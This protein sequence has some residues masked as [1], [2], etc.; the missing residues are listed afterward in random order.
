MN[1]HFTGLFPLWQCHFVAECNFIEEHLQKGDIV[2]LSKCDSQLS[3]CDANP[4]VN[5][6]KCLTCMSIRENAQRLLTKEIKSFQLISKETLL[7]IESIKIPNFQTREN[8]QSYCWNGINAGKEVISSIVTATGDLRFCPIKNHGLIKKLIR[9]YLKVYLTALNEIR[10][11]NISLVYIFNGRFAASRAWVRACEA[12]NINYITHDRLGLPDRMLKVTN[13]SPHDLSMYGDLINNYW[14]ENKSIPEVNSQ[15][16]DFFKERPL[17]SLTGWYSFV[18][19][20]DIKVLPAGWDEKKRNIAIFSST[21]S[22]FF[23]LSELFAGA[24]FTEQI[25]AYNKISEMVKDKKEMHFYL[26]IHPNSI[27]ENDKWWESH[28]LKKLKNLTII[29]PDSPISSYSLL[30]ACEKTIVFMST[31]GIEAT[32]WGKPSIAVSNTMYKGINAVYEPTDLTQLK[33]YILD[34]SMPPKPKERALAYGAYMRC[35]STRLPY[36]ELIDHCTLTFKGVRPNAS[37]AILN[38]LWKWEYINKKLQLPQWLENLW[39]KSEFVK[40]VKKL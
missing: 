3:A 39:T 10:Q 14:E 32:Y 6:P 15:A 7:D 37:E 24:L 9:D 29:E 31:M 30:M 12:A 40:L 18:K 27:H 20:Q 17:G 35:G 28:D 1:V 26:R 23:G 22:E 4:K 11:R 38:H 19:K 34:P 13:G 16:D 25:E 36:S 21:E 8:L 2:T 33:G 5:L